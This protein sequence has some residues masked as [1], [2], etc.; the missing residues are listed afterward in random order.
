FSCFA[1]YLSTK[2][3]LEACVQGVPG[4]GILRTEELGGQ[5]KPGADEAPRC[6]HF[7]DESLTILA[8]VFDG[9]AREIF[10]RRSGVIDFL[11]HR[12]GQLFRVMRSRP[13][14][15]SDVSADAHRFYRRA[16]R[17]R[18]C[19]ELS[20]YFDRVTHHV[21]EHATTLQASL[22]EPWH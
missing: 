17:A 12:R 2:E 15:R 7:A 9:R 1:F 8:L 19:E 5:A 3:H 22:P 13:L 18:L 4:H 6:G 10:R 11:S 16:W 20:H 14:E 21:V